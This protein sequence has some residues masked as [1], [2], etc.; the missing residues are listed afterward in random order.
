[1]AAFVL[2][3]IGCGG[4]ED[5]VPRTLLP[6]RF[7]YRASTTTKQAVRDNHQAC[8][9]LVG[10]THLHMGWRG[11]AL[12]NMRKVGSRLWVLELDNVPVGRMR[13]RISDPNACLM[14]ATGAVT[15]RVVFANDTLLTEQ[16]DT[17]GTGIEP[18]WSFRLQDD[19]T[20]LP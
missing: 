13:I 20:V 18:G 6:V 14:N 15:E 17:P 4:E 10:Q 8:F 12:E 2:S 9:G 7:E 16:V 5:V 3:G 1:M 11:F 19:G